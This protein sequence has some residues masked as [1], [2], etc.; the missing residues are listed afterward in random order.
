MT[1]KGNISFQEIHE[2]RNFLRN[3]E[4]R[5]TTTPEF[6]S[7]LMILRQ[8]CEKDS[9]LLEWTDS[10]AH[11][12]RN[13]G[14]TFEAGVGL[15]IERFQISAFFNSDSLLLEEIPVPVFERLL[16]LF[17][18][19]YFNFGGMDMKSDFPGGYSR[20]EMVHSLQFVYRK[21]E[22]EGVYKF[23]S[24]GEEN[25]DDLNLMRLF[26]SK[27]ESSSWNDS[28]YHFDRIRNDIVLALKKLIGA[29]QKAID[30]NADLLAAHFLSAFHLTEVDLKPRIQNSKTRCFLSVD[31][32]MSGHLS[33][34]LGLYEQQGGKWDA[35]ELPPANA[36]DRFEGSHSYT[37][38]F[39]LT[40]LEEEK[41]FYKGNGSENSFFG[42]IKVVS[43]RDGA[44][45]L[46]S[47]WNN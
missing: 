20:E 43:Q 28:P 9:A 45:F 5:R 23:I 36:D 34:N 6:K 37:R 33:L 16:A 13:R 32:T 24:A 27:L 10:V 46:K 31:S 30:D 17:K 19:P 39:L 21:S 1:A 11:K 7:V 38:P 29:N 26:I 47:V 8:Y 14:L 35:V 18:N 22:K 12:K 4:K 40:D 41:Y 42:A 2:L 25:F 3:L 44:C 15:W